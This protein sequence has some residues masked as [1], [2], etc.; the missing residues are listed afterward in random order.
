MTKEWVPYLWAVAATCK[1]LQEAE[2]FA[3]GQSITRVVLHQVLTFL[4]KKG[5]YWLTAE[6]MGK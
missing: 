1:I 5:D 4:E 2:E 3:L 6:E